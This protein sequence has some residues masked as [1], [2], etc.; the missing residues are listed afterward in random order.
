M[1]F[2][3]LEFDADTSKCSSSR[4]CE[5]CVNMAQS[6]QSSSYLWM[7]CVPSGFAGLKD[8][9]K[10]G[11]LNS[12]HHR[13]NEFIT[14]SFLDIPV[15]AS[16]VDTTAFTTNDRI[17]LT[18]QPIELDFEADVRWSI[19]ELSRAWADC[20]THTL[21]APQISAVGV[22]SSF[23]LQNLLK[24]W[25][26]ALVCEKFRLLIYTSSLMYNWGPKESYFG[27][28]QLNF[29]I[30][31]SLVGTALLE[32]LEELLRPSNLAKAVPE[33][34]RAIFIILFGTTLAVDYSSSFNDVP[35]QVRQMRNRTLREHTDLNRCHTIQEV[36][37]GQMMGFL[38]NK[39]S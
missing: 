21:H 10:F 38:N 27:S 7:S 31:H 3:N 24:E 12:N 23:Q 17:P 6:R 28:T 11:K 16:S 22:M 26:P 8:Y 13:R 35:A 19:G 5:R 4:P 30:I 32:S 20:I 36:P 2:G 34:L 29:C 9:F 14:N 39:S 18:T 33:M 15:A 25:I 37:K 1:T